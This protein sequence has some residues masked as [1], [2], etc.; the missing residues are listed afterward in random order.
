MHYSRQELEPAI[1]AL[2]E[3]LKRVPPLMRLDRSGKELR[4]IIEDTFGFKTIMDRLRS[5]SYRIES[6]TIFIFNTRPSFR[7][8]P[9]RDRHLNAAKSSQSYAIL[10][11]SQSINH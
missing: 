6:Y 5:P 4:D 9:G 1:D 7:S 3:V 8:D 11:L 10:S 2:I